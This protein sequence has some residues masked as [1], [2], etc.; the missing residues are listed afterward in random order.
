VVCA[1]GKG[2]YLMKTAGILVGTVMA[3]GGC[4]SCGGPKTMDM[5][6]VYAAIR[7]PLVVQDGTKVNVYR[8]W[9]EEAEDCLGMRYEFE[10]VL[11]IVARTGKDGTFAMNGVRGFRGYTAGQPNGRVVIMLGQADWLNPE[12]VRHESLH[13]ITGKRHGQLPEATFIKCSLGPGP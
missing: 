2:C 5:D 1:E 7:P 11:W 8:K 10:K 9:W 13:A 6:W 12:L 4:V 3:V